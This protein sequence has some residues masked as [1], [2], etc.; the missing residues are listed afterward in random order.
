MQTAKGGF[1]AP[2]GFEGG[3]RTTPA[4]GANLARLTISCKQ[5]CQHSWLSA[6]WTRR[7]PSLHRSPMTAMPWARAARFTS[8]TVFSKKKKE[9]EQAWLRRISQ[10]RWEG[11]ITS[12]GCSFLTPSPTAVAVATGKPIAPHQFQS[13]AQC[14][15]KVT[16]IR[17]TQLKLSVL[18]WTFTPV[19]LAIVSLHLD[20]LS[21]P[22]WAQTVWQLQREGQRWIHTIT[23]AVFSCLFWTVE[24]G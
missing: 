18:P 22:H 9:K 10:R 12:P 13:E 15:L 24:R 3:F 6:I 4:V 1:A 23:A 7:T 19:V 2:V 14:T 21:L 17:A 5:A 11:F 8:R 20:I 16:S